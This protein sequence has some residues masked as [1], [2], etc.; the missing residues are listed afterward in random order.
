MAGRLAVQQRPL[1][2]AVILIFS[3]VHCLDDVPAI[4]DVNLVIKHQTLNP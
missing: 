1:G 2:I 4:L 3:A